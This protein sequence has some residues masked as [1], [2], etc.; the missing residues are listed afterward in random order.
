MS[1]NR[2]T[3]EDVANLARVSK[4]TVSY[5]L[6]GR[7]AQARISA[8]TAEKVREAARELG[9]RPNGLAR[10]LLSKRTHTIALAFQYAGL[11]A[12]ESG[13]INELMAGV[14]QA[15]TDLGYDLVLHTRAP[16]PGEDDADVLTDGRCDGALLLRDMQ[17]PIASK[18]ADQGFPAVMFFTHSDD[19]RV[20]FV[21]A[22]NLGGAKMA[23]RHLVERGHTRIGLIHGSDAS[24]ASFDRRTGFAQA[25][26]HHGL[27]HRD[28]WHIQMGWAKEDP[29]ELS[30]L[31]ETP[32]RPSALVCWSDDVALEVLRLARD[33]GLS[34]PDDLAVVGFDSL[35]HC[36][37]SDPPLT[38]M[39]QPIREMAATATIALIDAIE[40]RREIPLRQLLPFSVDCRSST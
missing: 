33:A 14:C 40:G 15:A 27:P 30:R 24:F 2:T 35:V 8:A 19:P 23:V 18:L 11:F 4:V 34:I 9:Y 21:D 36:E 20:S 39:R 13:F 26:A 1:R 7:G 38:S 29:S 6:N 3:I 32:D 25:I 5:V 16:Q 28:D 22:D 37:R 31:L 17:D 12:S 10:R